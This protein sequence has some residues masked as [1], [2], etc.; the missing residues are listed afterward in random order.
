M[1]KGDRSLAEARSEKISLSRSRRQ[2]AQPGEKKAIIKSQPCCAGS[3]VQKGRRGKI[4]GGEA[5]KGASAV[6]DNWTDSCSRVA[7]GNPL[8]AKWR[9]IARAAGKHCVV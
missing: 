4:A 3:A 9:G 1:L 7:F 6:L 5:G 2:P 8:L